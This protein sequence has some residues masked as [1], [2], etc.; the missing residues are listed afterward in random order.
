MAYH[1]YHFVGEV[2][3]HPVYRPIHY[4]ESIKIALEV[5][6]LAVQSKAHTSFFFF[7]LSLCFQAN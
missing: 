4:F 2:L 5:F 1:P 6:T 3:L 7:F